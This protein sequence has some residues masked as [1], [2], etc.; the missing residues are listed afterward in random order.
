MYPAPDSTRIRDKKSQ[1]MHPVERTL[2]KL[3]NKRRERGRVQKQWT[4]A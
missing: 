3:Y 1:K 2:D 4:R